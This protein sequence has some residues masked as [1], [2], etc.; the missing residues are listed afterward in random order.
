MLAKILRVDFGLCRLLFFFS[1]SLIAFSFF[2]ICLFSIELKL[3]VQLW[4]TPSLIK[5]FWWGKY[6]KGIKKVPFLYTHRK[7]YNAEIIIKLFCIRFTILNC[8]LPHLPCLRPMMK[9]KNVCEKN[10]I[11]CK[12]EVPNNLHLDFHSLAKIFYAAS[13]NLFEKILLYC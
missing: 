5:N 3:S 4:K 6:G 7:W 1:F 11:G 2:L 9:V 13:V 10:S 12:Q 8:D